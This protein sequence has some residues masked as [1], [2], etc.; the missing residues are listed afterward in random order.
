VLGY[1]VTTA[2]SATTAHVIVA[3]HSWPTPSHVSAVA[4]IETDFALCCG[5]VIV[6]HFRNLGGKK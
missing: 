3:A 5:M 2:I 1:N 6:L 4:R